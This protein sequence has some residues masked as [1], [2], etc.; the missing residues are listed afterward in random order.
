MDNQLQ[1]RRSVWLL[2]VMVGLLPLLWVPVSQG[3]TT[4]ITSSGLNTQVSHGAG[5]PNYD[6]TGGTRPGNGTNLFHSFGD[7]SIGANHVA[8]F[9]NDSGLAT[10]NIL[11]RVTG[12]NP[13]NI[14]GTIQTTGFGNA[15]LF[16]M[17]PAGI[18]FGPTAS[19]N[20]GGSVTFT[21][22]DY[23]KL[24][25]G[26]RFRALANAS[27]DALLSAAPVAA[28]G[29]LG[30]NPGAITVQDSHLT[31]ADGKGISLVGGDIQ[32]TRG[33]LT[34]PGGQINLMSLAGRGEARVT[35]D[36]IAITP[37]TPRGNILV[38]GGDPGDLT[39]FDASGEEGGAVV[40]RGGRV[41]LVRVEATT[42][43][44]TANHTGAGIVVEAT[45]SATLDA[46]IL[47]TNTSSFPGNTTGGAGPVSLTA[48]SMTASNL[49][50]DTSAGN[51]GPAGD[52]AINVGSLKASNILIH[53]FVHGDSPGP[54]SGN[55]SIRATG[56]ITLQDGSIGT[57]AFGARDAGQV[58]VHAKSLTMTD[59]ASISSGSDASGLQ[60]G[61]RAGNI[62]ID[63]G[64]LTMQTSFI[65]PQI[66][67]STGTAG[68]GGDISVA[69]TGDVLINNGS[70]STQ[71]GG[72]A[73]GGL[74]TL[75]ASGLTLNHF[76]DIT[77][78]TLDGGRAGNISVHVRSL[79]MLNGGRIASYACCFL[80]DH[81]SAGNINIVAAKSIF[82]SGV[83]D[84]TLPFPTTISSTTSSSGHAG[85]VHTVTP[86]MHL[87]DRAVVSASS[88]SAGHAGRVV[89]DVGRLDIRGGAGI[90]S[91]GTQS[92]GT[93][94]INATRNITLDK[95]T[96]TA[97]GLSHGGHVNLHARKSILLRNGSLISA[98]G[99]NVGD[100]GHIAIHSGKSIV[101]RDSTVSA[102]AEQGN[103]GTIDVD[104]KRV[105]LTNSQLTT[106]ITG[107]PPTV[108]GEITVDAKYLTLRNSQILGTATEG[109]G[110]TITIR[111]HA[112]RRDTRSVIDASSQSG[113]DGT[114]TI[115]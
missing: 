79:N 98:D 13:S 76:G 14:F 105:T 36:G 45:K 86:T 111:S 21:T 51:N 2:M 103:G 43:A 46:V 38:N 69:A 108:G 41:S 85:R 93:I 74:I 82:M 84:V 56:D 92:A 32:M 110:G 64:R 30:S 1:M 102:K 91:T 95:G 81:G 66:S 20:V 65:V 47:R 50:I 80:S 53:S 40:I 9:L 115:E 28:F 10:T 4:S 7:F 94:L 34:A 88:E 33:A 15:N 112:L 3:Q 22:A 5:Q 67:T 113:T 75:S 70:I 19:L 29:F 71:T 89:L 72:I 90:E 62:V 83:S 27:A 31:V 6:I 42:E 101:I 26:V 106:S 60:S 96:I 109:Q 49:T 37:R 58:S 114:V 55:V 44:T 97:A 24:A 61:G 54:A 73:D 18:V 11:S 104:A 100:A 63:V 25:D 78:A 57:S 17:N 35:A 39:Q 8:Q 48:P 87:D 12:G 68:H 59:G 77:T 107:G 99:S 52:V 23:L 16:L